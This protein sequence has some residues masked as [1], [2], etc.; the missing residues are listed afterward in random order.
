L[1]SINYRLQSGGPNRQLIEGVL[2]FII[3]LARQLY[4]RTYPI[5][6]GTTVQLSSQQ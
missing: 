6:A 4:C 5:R 3:Q 2:E 1:Y